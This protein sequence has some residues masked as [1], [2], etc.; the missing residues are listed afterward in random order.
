MTTSLPTTRKPVST[1]YIATGVSGGVLVLLAL[2]ITSTLIV[3]LIVMKKRK[4]QAKTTGQL[5]GV[6]HVHYKNCFMIMQRI[7]IATG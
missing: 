5:I 2:I 4:T 6:M 7:S 3:M 1:V